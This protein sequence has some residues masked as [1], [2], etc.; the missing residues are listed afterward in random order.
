MLSGA[1]MFLMPFLVDIDPQADAA[2][3]GGQRLLIPK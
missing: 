2:A 1:V 3:A